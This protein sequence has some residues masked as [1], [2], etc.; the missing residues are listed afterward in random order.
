VGGLL[1]TGSKLT[2][3]TFKDG[4]V[5]ITIIGKEDTQHLFDEMGAIVFLNDAVEIHTVKALEALIDEIGNMLVGRPYVHHLDVG[6]E[7]EHEYLYVEG[8]NGLCKRFK[9]SI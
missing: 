4:V 3:D 7:K 9:R 2:H 1:H 6:L 8:L 5:E